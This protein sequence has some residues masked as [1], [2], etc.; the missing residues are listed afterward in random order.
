MQS[1]T[2]DANVGANTR[3][4]AP[5]TDDQLLAIVRGERTRSI[6]FDLDPE[7]TDAREKA[8]NY[9]KGE[10]PD[11]PA[12]PNRSKATASDIADAVETVLPDLVEIFTGGDDVV[13]FNPKNADDEPQAD[14]ETEYVRHVVFDDND[15]FMTFV[16]FFKDALLTKTG[17]VKSWWEDGPVVDPEQFVGKTAAELQLA[18]QDGEIS[19][20]SPSEGSSLDDPEPLFD[21]TL[22][23]EGPDGRCR[24]KAIAPED[25]TVARD[26]VAL[27]DTSYAA[28]R[29]RPRAQELIADGH[30]ADIIDKL[31][32]Y[33]LA[34][35]EQVQLARDTAGE[36]SMPLGNDGPDKDRRSVEVVEHY[37]RCL[38]GAK[39]E[40]W[41][42]VTG[43]NE[44]ILIAK[45]RV[46]RMP[47]A[48]I[49]PY[50]VPHRFYGESLADK[51]IEIQRIKTALLRM[52]LDHGYFALNQ[53]YSVDMTK[54]NEFTISDLLDNRP[55]VPIRGMGPDVVTA[56]QS[57]AAPYDFFGALEYMSTQGESRTGVVRNAQGLNPDT[58]HDTA[59]GAAMLAGQAQRRVRMIARVFAETG[60]KDLYLDVHALLRTHASK[61]VITKLRGQWIPVDPSA[62]QERTQVTVEVGVGSGGKEQRLAMLREVITLQETV[63]KLP[64]A[65]MLVSPENAYSAFIDAMKAGGLK[66]G[67]S[68]FTDPKTVTPQPQQPNP[69]L[70]K[71]QAGQQND[72]TRAQLDGAKLQSEHVTAQGRLQLDAAR[73]QNDAQE[74][75][76]DRAAQSHAET[77]KHQ[78]EVLALHA[79][80]ERERLK[81]ATDE[82][83]RRQELA[84]KRADFEERQSFNAKKLQQDGEMAI[85]DMQTKYSTHIDGAQI[86]AA[87]EALKGR[88]DLATQG[89]RSIDAHVLAAGERE[90]EHAM[91]DHQAAV[92]PEPAE[93]KGEDE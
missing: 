46:D 37:I 70:L 69:E 63:V 91:V 2:A 84:L 72:Q 59:T 47:F 3:S 83:I 71:L 25:F 51:L 87:A 79:S 31:P 12:L 61:Q 82:D 67:A 39:I 81:L 19:D 30:D 27:K 48:A 15:G 21:F 5:L 74:S 89:I 49:T 85:L 45:E 22:T 35:D 64:G 7:L 26:T 18:E 78:R 33:G 55:G 92:A 90:H 40:I 8:L 76:A 65:A 57:G 24:I 14:Q 11:I 43:G 38:N 16:G 44:S 23:R 13:S 77:L 32:P 86:K 60:V 10:M 29:S 4:E 68:Y 50:V 36:H 54:A 6:G 75:A 93:P 28:F 53:R 9:A 52:A 58:L 41:R 56:I 88:N 73:L 20:V 80:D 1:A 66:S 62:W 42:V 17:I 34:R